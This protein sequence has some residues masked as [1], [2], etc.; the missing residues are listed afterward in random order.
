MRILS[1]LYF[2]DQFREELQGFIMRSEYNKF[3]ILLSQKI[4][5]LNDIY[6]LR[7]EKAMKDMF[8]LIQMD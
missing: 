5:D 6:Y 1:I 3:V 8:S 7:F 2:R 4:Y